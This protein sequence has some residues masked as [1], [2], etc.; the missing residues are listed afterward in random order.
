MKIAYTDKQELSL[1]FVVA[2]PKCLSITQK[3]VSS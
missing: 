3:V 1:E 2:L